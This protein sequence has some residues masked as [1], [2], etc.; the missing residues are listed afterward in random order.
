MDQDVTVGLGPD[1]V[2]TGGGGSPAA[3]HPP[4]PH[5]RGGRSR[6]R[7]VRMR[8]GWGE[9]IAGLY[10]SGVYL[11][12]VMRAL[13]QHRPWWVIGLYSAIVIAGLAYASYGVL[14]W[15]TSRHLKQKRG[16]V[17]SVA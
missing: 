1:G 11:R 4:N 17:D 16:A 10:G 9:F 12:H 14:K 13:E 6:L 15:I 7:Q 5:R 8:S 2:T 3:S